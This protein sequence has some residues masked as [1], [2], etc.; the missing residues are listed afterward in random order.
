MTQHCLHLGP[1]TGDMETCG[2]C[3]NNTRLK[4]FSCSHPDHSTTTIKSCLTCPDFVL[5]LID[6]FDRVCVINL[7]RRQDRL[8]TFWKNIEECKW[9]FKKPEVVEAIDGQIVRAPKGWTAG[10]GAYGCKVTHCR[11]LEMALMEGVQHLLVLEDDA[12]FITDFVE[13]LKQ[14][15]IALPKDYDGLCLGGQ[16]KGN[17]EIVT[18]EVYRVFNCQR[19]HAYSA[20]PRLQQ[21]L[22]R[23]WSAPSCVDHIDHIVGQVQ[24]RFNVYAPRPSFLIGQGESYSDI[25]GSL[26]AETFWQPKL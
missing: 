14:F 20:R 24:E 12:V 9:P 13:R 18:E 10:D 8:E 26:K 11:T 4:I 23:L 15:F 16:N 22:Y 21:A 2:P 1:E 19:T 6:V 5:P 3:K 7:K 17:V 25:R